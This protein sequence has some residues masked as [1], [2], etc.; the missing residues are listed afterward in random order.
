MVFFGPCSVAFVISL[1]IGFI[2]VSRAVSLLEGGSQL[3]FLWK[4]SMVA[5]PSSP[6][7]FPLSKKYSLSLSRRVNSFTSCCNWKLFHRGGVGQNES[8]LDRSAV[9]ASVSGACDRLTTLFTCDLWPLFA[10]NDGGICIGI[11]VYYI[12]CLDVCLIKTTWS[13]NVA[14]R[15]LNFLKNVHNYTVSISLDARWSS[16]ALVI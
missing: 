2:Y 9:S 6:S 3:D 5:P 14:Q 10:P 15:W 4:G 7:T 1:L 8:P 12:I 11:N 13:Q 16:I